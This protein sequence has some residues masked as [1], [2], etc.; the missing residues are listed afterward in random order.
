MFKIGDKVKC[1]VPFGDE[2]V[3]EKEYTIENAD[4]FDVQLK[5]V[6][7]WWMGA[8]FELVQ[9]NKQMNVKEWIQNNAWF[10]RI[11]NEEQFNLVQ[12]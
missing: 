11:K 7:G 3:Y 1:V 8:R 2:V 4:E 12:E 10:I 6:D 9:E 5:G